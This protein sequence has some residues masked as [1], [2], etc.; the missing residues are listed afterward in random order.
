[1]LELQIFRQFI[2]ERLH[3]L[4]TGKGF[5]DEFEME[6]VRFQERAHNAGGVEAAATRIKMQY[7]QFSHAAKRGGGALVKT[8]KNKVNEREN[9]KSAFKT[10]NEFQFSPATMR[11]QSTKSSDVRG[12]GFRFGIARATRTHFRIVAL[13]VEMGGSQDI[14]YA[15]LLM[16]CRTVSSTCDSC[17]FSFFVQTF[18]RLTGQIKSDYCIST[19][20]SYLMFR[21]HRM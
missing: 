12:K 16:S 13:H 5:S 7:S 3:M 11:R 8:V 17:L 4:N 1:M 9:S 18:N 14:G 20:Y 19:M 6:A 21:A 10:M 2:E 15:Q